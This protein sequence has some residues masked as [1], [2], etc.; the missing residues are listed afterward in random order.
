MIIPVGRPDDTQFLTRLTRDMGGNLK[1]EQI[2]PVA[3]VPLVKKS[4]DS[5]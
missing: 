1:E 2:L 5:V 4:A 3:F